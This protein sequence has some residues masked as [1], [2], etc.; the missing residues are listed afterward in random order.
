MRVFR[1]L[2]TDKRDYAVLRVSNDTFYDDY[3]RLV[4]KYGEGCPIKFIIQESCNFKCPRRTEQEI[5]DDIVELVRSTYK[6][7]I[8]KGLKDCIYYEYEIGC[9]IKYTMQELSKI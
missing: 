3:K 8:S 2:I 9:L 4:R 1:N 6:S 7:K 5:K